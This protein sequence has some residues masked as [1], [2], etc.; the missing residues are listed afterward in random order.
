[1]SGAADQSDDDVPHFF[2]SRTSADA[3]VAIEVANALIDAGYRVL[4]QDKDFANKNFMDMM[5]LGLASDARV[6]AIMSEDYFRS[7]H[8]RAE[9]E[10]P[11]A[12]DPL[13]SKARLIVLRARECMPRGL[14][15]AIAYWDLVKVRS[16][17]AL[18][19]AMVLAAVDPVHR[20]SPPLHE[21]CSRNSTSPPTAGTAPASST[22]CSSSPV[23]PRSPPPR[24]ESSLSA[25]TK[26]FW[27]SVSIATMSPAAIP[28][29]G[30]R[31]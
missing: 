30:A 19:K 12:D 10:H 8:C 14:L 16:T 9:W 6:I 15:K 7:D 26:C 21:H 22:P 11:L 28:A 13:N 17:P 25:S 18:L 5:D 23:S 24:A 4:I 1:M 2:V 29:P 27:S 31:Q 3:A 20:T